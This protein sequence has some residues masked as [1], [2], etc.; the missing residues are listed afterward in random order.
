[1]ETELGGIFENCHKVTS[2]RTA[3]VNMVHQEPPT[4]VAT[5]N[6]AANSIFN[7]TAKQKIYQAI[8][9]RWYWV[10]DRIRQHHFHVFWEEGKKNLA[11]CVTKIHPIYQHRTMRPRYVKAKK[12]TLKNQDAA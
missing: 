8:D 7:R 3:Q 4:P 6:T 11:D 2:M 12:N 1:M 10:R 9:M 5:E